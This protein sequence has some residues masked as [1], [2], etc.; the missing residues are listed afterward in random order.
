MFTKG[1]G[2]IMGIFD[3]GKNKAQDLEEQDQQNQGW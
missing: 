3:R 2:R 1:T